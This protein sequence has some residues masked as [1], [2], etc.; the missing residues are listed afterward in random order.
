MEDIAS[1]LLIFTLIAFNA[2]F[3][4]AEF[5]VA[6]VRKT[7]IDHIASS[8][9]QSP[10]TRAAAKKLQKILGDI[11]DCVSA[12]QIGITIASLAL[13]A[14]AEARLEKI[15]A[16]AFEAIPLPLD[17]HLVSISIA[18]TL[19]TFLHVILGEVVPKNIAI[20]H[21]EKTSLFLTYFLSFLIFIFKTPIKFM[22]FCSNLILD[23]L[24]VEQNE[25]G[26]IHSEDELKMILSSSQAHGVLEEEEEELMQNIFEFNDTVAKDVM[27]PRTDMVCLED[28]L[29]V[30]EAV[31]EVSK[32]PHSRFPVFEGRLDNI[33]GYVTI[34]DMLFAYDKGSAATKLKDISNEM[35]KVPDGMYIIDLIKEMQKSKKQLAVLIDE[36]GG[37]SGLVT[38]EDIVEELFGELEDEDETPKIPILKLNTNEYLIDGLV[39]LKEVNDMVGSSFESEHYDTIGGFVFGL[40]GSEPKPGDKVESDHYVLKVEK[41]DAN[42]V[43]SVRVTKAQKA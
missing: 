27:V 23:L 10:G 7:Q 11:N 18:I 28:H 20:F 2:V 26:L 36:F 12:C 33:T 9:E 3:V 39:N 19:I 32:V 6:R 22:N 14:V 35:L 4:A 43:R 29:S 21:P 1:I 30:A 15:I 37:T 8:E 34:R 41:H 24:N 38:A 40:I 42:R 31:K 5:A 17:S 13:G 25:S 16:P